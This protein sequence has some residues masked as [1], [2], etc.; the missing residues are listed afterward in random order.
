MWS[1]HIEHEIGRLS[2]A[3][4]ARR[5]SKLEARDEGRE[6]RGFERFPDVSC[7]LTTRKYHEGGGGGGLAP[8]P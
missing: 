7:S 5:S 2:R 4:I 1:K 3:V 6:T 8:L